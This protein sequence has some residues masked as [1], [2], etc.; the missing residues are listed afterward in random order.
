MGRNKALVTFAV[1][2]T[3]LACSSSGNPPRTSA[4]CTPFDTQECWGPAACKGGQMCTGDGTGW[5]ICD[6]GSPSS[7]SSN[8]DASIVD[9]S[10]V[11]A[12][13][14]KS[15]TN[16][17]LDTG[18]IRSGT[19]KYWLNNNVWGRPSNDNTSQQCIWLDCLSGEELSWGTGWTW[20]DGGNSVKAYPSVVLGWQ[21]GVGTKVSNT[22]LPL[23]LSALSAIESGWNFT[24]NT[25]GILDVSYDILLHTI[26]NPDGSGSGANEPSNEVMIW[27]YTAGL[28]SPNGTLVPGAITLGG[29]SWDLWEGQATSNPFL[30]DTFVRTTNT[31]SS[32]LNISDFLNYLVSNR[33][34]DS[35]K[36]L[37]SVQAGTEVAVGSGELDTS[38]YYCTVQ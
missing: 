24:V 35:S 7:G 16:T 26:P 8:P 36:Y 28:L 4:L 38:S 13:D 37:T 31:N 20:A 6:C 15:S 29:T 21:F 12:D 1:G 33:G 22:G 32:V 11:C 2:F 34:L 23:Q 18:T 27:L 19:G 10:I 3:V 9:A 25:V 30:T 14:L 5:T 17:C